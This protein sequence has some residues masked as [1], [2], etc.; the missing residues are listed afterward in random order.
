[1]FLDVTHLQSDPKLASATIVQIS[2]LDIANQNLVWL[3]FDVVHKHR[4]RAYNIHFTRQPKPHRQRW[5]VS[6]VLIAPIFEEY[7]FRG[8]IAGAIQYAYGSVAAWLLS[9]VIFGVA[10]GQPAVM[11]S[12]TMSGLVLGFY[13]LRSRSV[14]IP[15]IL[16]A[17]N[18]LTVCFLQTFDA[19]ELT[20]RQLIAN[21]STYWTVQIICSVVSLV[22]LTRMF[23]IIRG[24]KNDK[25]L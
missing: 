8:Y 11:V 15:M 4:N 14:M 21:D 3:Y 16:H 1:M 6:A 23:F 7:L 12:A 9:S 25:Y 24:Q 5:L 10:H 13:F 19:G 20:F 2:R 22:V 18:N 17:M